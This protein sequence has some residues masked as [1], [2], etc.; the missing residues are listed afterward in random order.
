MAQEGKESHAESVLARFGKPLPARDGTLLVELEHG[1]AEVGPIVIALNEAGLAVESLDLVQPTLDDVFVAKTGQHLEGDD[2][3]GEQEAV[4]LNDG[5]QKRLTAN[6]RVVAALGARSV[7]QT[8]APA[9]AR[10]AAV[11]LPDPAAGDPDRRR[12]RAPWTCPSSRPCESF[13]AFMLAGAM[14]QSVLLAGNSGAIA[15]ALDIEMGFTD[16]LFAAP[17]LPLRRRPGPARRDR[18]ARRA[19]SPSGSSRSG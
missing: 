15:L 4:T 6:A 13:L 19:S 10:G 11:H 14:V 2:E 17:D 3:T 18:D 7:K 12:R 9:T 1:T 16:R 8:A 5:I